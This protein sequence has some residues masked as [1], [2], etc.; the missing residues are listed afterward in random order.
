MKN[1]FFALAAVALALSPTAA[2]AAMP[3]YIGTDYKQAANCQVGVDHGIFELVNN[4]YELTGCITPDAWSRA[5]ALAHRI[6]NAGIKFASGTS[7][8]LKTGAAELCPIWFGF[9]GCVIAPE[10]V[11]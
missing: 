2:F 9:G 5:E 11:R 3:N 10:L 6:Q 7:L 4:N 8:T 1:L